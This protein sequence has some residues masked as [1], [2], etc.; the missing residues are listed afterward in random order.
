M[1]DAIV[2]GIYP[3]MSARLS[4]PAGL[5]AY[6]NNVGYF[7]NARS[8]E[9]YDIAPF[10]RIYWSNDDLQMFYKAMQVTEPQIME[11]VSKTYYYPQASF[12]PRCA[13]DPF[14]C[15]QLMVIRYFLLKKMKKELDLSIVYF[16]FSGSFYP[17]IHY[18][19][20]PKVQ[21]SE[22]RYIMEHVV[23]NVL[24]QRFDLKQEKNVIGAVK[25]I[26]MTWIKSYEDRIKSSD[27]DDCV[28]V[29]QQLHNRIK[30]FMIN[31][32]KPY[33]EAYDKK[34][35]Y[36]NYA[37]DNDSEDNYRVADNDSLK[38]ERYVNKSMNY[39]TTSSS[40]N[41]EFC[42]LASD[43]N[44]KTDE[45]KAIIQSIHSDNSNMRLVKELLTIMIVEYLNGSMD[46]EVTGLSFLNSATSP[47]PNSKNKNILREKEILEEI[48]GDNSPA[49]KRRSSRVPTKNSYHRSILMYYA[50]VVNK[51]NK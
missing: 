27:D 14:V 13:K 18:G 6:K 20:F 16:A 10:T 2:K 24:S 23:N 41:Y 40:V 48:L 1:T 21:P 46:K 33:Y 26:G 30:S 19:S 44:V 38:A 7:L 39:L 15:S 5:T 28:Y 35:V 36:F 49:Y 47:K 17:S 29:I 9:L 34:D 32:A 37:S 51:A 45:L 50:L 4:T 12:N 22:Y 11:H 43:S 42:K 8:K 31:I 25:S 3:I